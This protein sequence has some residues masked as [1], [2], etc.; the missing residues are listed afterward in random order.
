[1][2]WNLQ[3]EGFEEVQGVRTSR[4]PI[5]DHNQTRS[6]QEDNQ[7]GEAGILPCLVLHQRVNHHH[8]DRTPHHQCSLS[9][10]TRRPQCRYPAIWTRRV[11]RE[12][13]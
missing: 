4:R 11:E 2:N 6:D 8:I 13:V 3:W 7:D 1:M 10:P 12:K 5:R 9:L